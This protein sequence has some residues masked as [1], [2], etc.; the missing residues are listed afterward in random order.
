MTLHEFAH[1]YHTNLA[2]MARAWGI[3]VQTMK[4]Y[5]MYQ[6]GRLS[7]AGARRP[8]VERIAHIE[9]KSGG[10]ITAADWQPQAGGS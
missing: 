7:T 9:M 5:G 8:S 6:R 2:A 4:M 1:R 10:L 3:P